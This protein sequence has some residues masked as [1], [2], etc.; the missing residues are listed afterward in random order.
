LL[1]TF[2]S[3][4]L[5]TGVI[6]RR[7]FSPGPVTGHRFQGAV[8]VYLSV[9]ALFAIAYDV[10]EAHVPGAIKPNAGEFITS[11]LEARRA[12]L[13]YFSL[14]TITTTG[15]GDLT[16]VHPLARSLVNLE[17]G[18]GM[19]FPATFIARLVALRSVQGDADPE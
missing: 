18:F 10:L 8:F 9:A 4:A 2:V 19:L 14:A 15:Y 11:A 13:S 16:P 1:V 12:E 7:T 3:K 6:A 17:A 5:V